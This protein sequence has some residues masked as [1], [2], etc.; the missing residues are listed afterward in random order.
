MGRGFGSWPIEEARAEGSSADRKEVIDHSEPISGADCRECPEGSLLGFRGA[1]GS[2]ATVTDQHAAGCPAGLRPEKDR[3]SRE[4]SCLD[5]AGGDYGVA[6]EAMPVVQVEG[7]SD[8]LPTAPEEI[9]GDLGC[10]G[11]VVDPSRDVELT[12]RDC[13]RVAGHPARPGEQP[14]RMKLWRGDVMVMVET[15]VRSGFMEAPNTSSEG[16]GPTVGTVAR[17]EA[18]ASSGR[19]VQVRK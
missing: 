19:G 1:G 7:E 6:D 5:P 16:G 12:V 11:R 13:L 2:V 10:R 18:G 4:A 14:T 15:S 17:L 3:A 9:E 8:I